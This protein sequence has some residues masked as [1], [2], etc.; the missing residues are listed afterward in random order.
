MHIH[1]QNNNG[2]IRLR[3]TLQGTRYNLSLQGLKFDHPADVAQAYAIAARIIADIQLGSFD[4]TLAAYRLSPAPAVL[5][6]TELPLLDL[7]DAWVGQSAASDYAKAGHYATTRKA[8]LSGTLLAPHI[9]ATTHNMRL[10]MINKIFAWGKKKGFCDRN[11]YADVRP[12]RSKRSNIRVFKLSELRAIRAVVAQY[13]PHYLSFLEFL[14]ISGCRFGEAAAIRPA[15]IDLEQSAV[16]INACV[17]YNLIS[18]KTELKSGTKT[19]S[20][21][22][23]KSVQLIQILERVIWPV[24]LYAPVFTAPRGG[25]ILRSNFRHKAW[26]PALKRAAVP[27]RNMHVLRH[28]ALSHALAQGMSVPDVAYLAGHVDGSMVIRTYGHMINRPDLPLLD[29]GL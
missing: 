8:I 12:K 22:V 9:A 24:D 23:L 1:P 18:R 11:P 21:R 10:H 16:T 13:W 20:E 19:G 3:F 7:W 14:M 6:R 28:T 26:V 27:Y 29:L 17:R 25:L 5:A 15:V 2:A 4:S